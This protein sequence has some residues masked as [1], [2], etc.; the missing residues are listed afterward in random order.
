MKKVFKIDLLGVD[1][2]VCAVDKWEAFDFL[3]LD[4]DENIIDDV[5]ENMGY[6]PLLEMSDEEYDDF[7][8]KIVTEE[9][10][11]NQKFDLEGEMCTFEDII[12]RK[13]KTPFYLCHELIDAYEVQNYSGCAIE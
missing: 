4:T 1:E 8:E 11:L 7:L 13:I 10:N 9:L 12:K 6:P 3:S 5:I 2:W